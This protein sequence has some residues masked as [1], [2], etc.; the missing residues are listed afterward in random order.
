[1]DKL[2]G[3]GADVNLPVQDGFTA[4][5]I[6]AQNGDDSVVDA[7][8]RA[9]AAVNMNDNAQWTPLFFACQYGHL[10][11]VSMRYPNSDSRLN[12]YTVVKYAAYKFVGCY[13]LLLYFLIQFLLQLAFGLPILPNYINPSVLQLKSWTTLNDYQ[14]NISCFLLLMV[15][16]MSDNQSP[17]RFFN[18]NRSLIFS[19][20]SSSQKRFHWI[21]V[22]VN[23]DL[24]VSSW[25]N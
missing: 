3:K 8:L 15:C 21:N 25:T 20:I 19:L 24:F 4:L 9:G 5:H 2:I 1:M 13:W 10:P 14:S 23:F 18:H 22:K 6:A 11:V 12:L 7:L 17:I 16:G